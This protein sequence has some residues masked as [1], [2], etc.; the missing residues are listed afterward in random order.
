[1]PGSATSITDATSFGTNDYGTSTSEALLQIVAALIPPTLLGALL[2]P[3]L[4]GAAVALGGAWLLLNRKP[5]AVLWRQGEKPLFWIRFAIYSLVLS[6]AVCC[7][8]AVGVLR[9]LSGR[10]TRSA[11]E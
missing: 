2:W 9:N 1:M 8:A 6:Y 11:R 4:A 5:L 7:G 10:N 3:P